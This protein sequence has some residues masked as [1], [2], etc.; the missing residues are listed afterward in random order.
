[1]N[2]NV[3][4]NAD[5]CFVCG[6]KNP[7]GLKIKFTTTEETCVGY[8]KANETHVGYDNTV[9]GGII[10]S[11]LDDV[12]ANV[13][14]LNNIKA[15]TAQCEIRYRKP[16]EID[17]EVKLIGKVTAKKRRLITLSGQAISTST[18]DI[19]AECEAKFMTL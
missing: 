3:P 18:K 19:I 15:H 17:H 2:Q 5:M 6:S 9:H 7:I 8:F 14:Y 4:E 12:M 1:M 10:F 13:L 16:L 11:A